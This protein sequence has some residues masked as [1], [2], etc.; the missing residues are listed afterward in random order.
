MAPVFKP[1]KMN[2]PEKY[3]K[4]EHNIDKIWSTICPGNHNTPCQF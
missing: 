4:E 1:Q 3:L 2:W